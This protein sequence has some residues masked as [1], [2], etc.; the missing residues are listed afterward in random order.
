MH[1]NH[2]V[3]AIVPAYNEE[4]KVARVVERIDRSLVDCVLVV[5]DGSTDQ[6]ARVSSDR[7]AEVLSLQRRSGVG[8]A[9]RAGLELAKAKDFDLAVI[10]AGNNKDDPLEIPRLLDPICAGTSDFVIG[11]RYLAGGRCGGDMP[12]YRRLATRLHPWLMSLFCGKR[13]T[14]STNGFRA[15]RLALLSDARIDLHQPW[16]DRYGLEVYL[17]WKV[18]TLGYRHLE[19]P[20]TKVYPSKAVGRTKMRPILDWWSILRPVFSLGLGLRR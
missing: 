14:E 3:I 12:L 2:S 17:L 15:F 13:L 16:L 20:C 11:S 19:V 18:I 5:D 6:T 7:G 8:A 10:L 1:K 4:A 9:L